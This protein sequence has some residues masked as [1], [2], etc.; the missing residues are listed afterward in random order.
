MHLMFWQ[1]KVW[2]LRSQVFLLCP[3]SYNTS[4]MSSKRSTKARAHKVKL[5]RYGWT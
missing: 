1:F 3:H 5:K 2:S 4:S